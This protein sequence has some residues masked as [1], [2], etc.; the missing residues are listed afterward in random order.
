MSRVSSTAATRPSWSLKLG[1]KVIRYLLATKKHVL[2]FL[3]SGSRKIGVFADASFE[4]NGSQSGIA[5]FYD[6]CLIEWRSL[7]QQTIAR[8][9]A[10]SEITSMSMGEQ[11]LEGIEAVLA[12][13]GIFAEAKLFGDNTAAV[14]LSQGQGSWRTRSYANKAAALRSRVEAGTL[15]IEY[16]GTADQ[17]ADILTKFLAVPQMAVARRQLNICVP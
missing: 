8:A 13:M 5:I 1:K 2:R 3:S 10:E 15:K 16:V 9:T 17:A 6:G 14:V 11:M 12:D 7:R 4:P